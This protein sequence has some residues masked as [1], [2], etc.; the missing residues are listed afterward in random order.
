MRIR[1]RFAAA[2]VKARDIAGERCRRVFARPA[3]TS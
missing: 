2:T 1:S 3:G